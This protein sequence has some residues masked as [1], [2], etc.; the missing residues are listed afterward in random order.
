MVSRFMLI[1]K[2]HENSLTH[3]S[4]EGCTSLGDIERWRESVNSP[5]KHRH[6]CH[7]LDES[8]HNGKKD[9]DKH[10]RKPE[11][12]LR[13]CTIESVLLKFL[14]LCALGTLNWLQE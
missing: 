4:C 12:Y 5:K 8:M 3:L 14:C 7:G 6:A 9:V 11:L 10:I 1:L 2:D 13:I